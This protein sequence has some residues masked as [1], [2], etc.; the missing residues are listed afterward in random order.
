MT[1]VLIGCVNGTVTRGG[2][3]G[4]KIRKF[5]RRHLSIAPKGTTPLTLAAVKGNNRIVELLLNRDDIQI[6]KGPSIN[7]VTLE[8]GGCP[9]HDVVREVAWI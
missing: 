6:N 2:G 4:P 9:L 3:G 7:D 1:I 5:C 8:R